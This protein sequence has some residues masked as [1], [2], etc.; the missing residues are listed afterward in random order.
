MAEPMTVGLEMASFPLTLG[1]GQAEEELP[2]WTNEFAVGV[3]ARSDLMR[4]VG[5][6]ARICAQL[7]HAN[8]S[9]PALDRHVSH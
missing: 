5:D 2:T 1:S 7:L 9:C 4:W 8:R 3:S 6:C